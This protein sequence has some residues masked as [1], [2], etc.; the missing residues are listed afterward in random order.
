M[1]SRAMAFF[2]VVWAS[3]TLTGNQPRTQMCP[4]SSDGMNSRPNSG[5]EP[6]LTTNSEA[7]TPRKSAR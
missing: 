5:S 1:I 3:E 7:N 2:S 6:M 4:S